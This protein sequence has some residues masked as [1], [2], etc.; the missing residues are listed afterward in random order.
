MQR[1]LKT[2][3]TNIVGLIVPDVGNGYYAMVAR[4][5]ESMLVKLGYA[6]FLVCTEYDETMEE[7]YLDNLLQY[8]VEGIIIAYQLT[9]PCFRR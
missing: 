4:N 6:V 9:K 1:A 5:V 2:N 8:N 3:K 7:S